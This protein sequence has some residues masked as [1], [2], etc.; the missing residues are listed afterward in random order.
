[1]HGGGVPTCTWPEVL[2]ATDEDS[3]GH[4][5]CPPLG[6]VH[7]ER[8]SALSPCRLL[9]GAPGPPR[10]DVI[11]GGRGCPCRCA[12]GSAGRTRRAAAQGALGAPDSRKQGARVGAR[13]R[14]GRWTAK[15]GP[16]GSCRGSSVKSVTQGAKS[17]PRGPPAERR[18]PCV[19]TAASL[20]SRGGHTCSDFRLK[21]E[22]WLE[23]WPARWVTAE[24][25][26]AEQRP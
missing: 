21:T 6:S 9:S 26:A 8:T 23:G 25:A 18:A 19:G 22:T 16:V 17:G 1:M 7:P 4:R 14:R 3:R 12:G 11:D 20:R 15:W 24:G 10:E 13:W 5:P 2:S